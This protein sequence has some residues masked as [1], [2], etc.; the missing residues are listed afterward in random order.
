MS[1]PGEG[2][3]ERL[4]EGKGGWGGGGGNDGGLWLHGAT[5]LPPER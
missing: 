2:G 1:G 4:I 5:S 3:G